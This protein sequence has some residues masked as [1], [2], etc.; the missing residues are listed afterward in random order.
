MCVGCRDRAATTDLVRVVAIAGAA[1]PDIGRRLPGRGA[2][3]HP[4]QQCLD[5]AERTKALPRAL[6][7]SGP[8]D[9]TAL[10]ALVTI[11]RTPVT[12]TGGTDRELKDA[13]PMST[14]A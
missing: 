9:L 3:L 12:A 4:S 5:R 14:Q 2:S 11:E 10:R 8:L 7:V 13:H 6:R 1:V